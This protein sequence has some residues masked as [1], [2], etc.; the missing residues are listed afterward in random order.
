MTAILANIQA[1]WFRIFILLVK[2]IIKDINIIL[3][4]QHRAEGNK[5]KHGMKSIPL[6]QRRIGTINKANMTK[7]LSISGFYLG[8]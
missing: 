2:R 4:E 8:K 7:L 1:Y 5:S 6:K 3:V